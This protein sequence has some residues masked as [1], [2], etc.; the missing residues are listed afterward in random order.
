MPSEWDIG[1]F[2]TLVK[3]KIGAP[4]ENA[5]LPAL[6]SIPEKFRFCHYH[7]SRALELMSPHK[8]EVKD[9]FAQTAAAMQML[10]GQSEEERRRF[11]EA[12]FGARAH[13]VAFAQSLH[14]T[15]DYL[16]KVIYRGLDL[17]GRHSIS[18]QNHQ[19][20]LARIKDRISTVT[21]LATVKQKIED[22]LSSS[23]F[24][25]LAAFVNTEKHHEI[26]DATFSLSFS[27]GSV[28]SSGLR[29]KAFQYNG[30]SFAEK[31]AIDFFEK[32]FQSILE[33]T[34]EVGCALNDYLKTI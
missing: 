17:S 31:W 6:E 3:T 15:A 25:Y 13:A 2:A 22:Y 4:H 28:A 27:V 20:G 11:I 7:Y 10:F 34:A 5:M 19:I 21:E 18:I 32:D 30:N 29:M 26:V 9:H 24:L 14:S 23:S 8:K 16:A 12:L 1:E 33:R